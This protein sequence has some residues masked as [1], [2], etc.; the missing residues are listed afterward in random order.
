MIRRAWV[1]VALSLFALG[2]ASLAGFARL[3][4]IPEN[5]GGEVEVFNGAA[6]ALVVFY[7]YATIWQLFNEPLA[8]TSN[9]VTLLFV[10]V[11]PELAAHFRTLSRVLFVYVSPHGGG[12]GAAAL[13]P[14]GVWFVQ[15]DVLF[16]ITEADTHACPLGPFFGPLTTHA[17]GYV[18]IPD[19]V[20]TGRPFSFTIDGVNFLTLGPFCG[21]AYVAP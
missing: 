20:D 16:S 3:G 4:D 7:D 8:T 11:A 2:A 15:D 9:A 18:R 6:T 10:E 14:A 5:L 1:L 21:T 12:D 13:A 19:G 17:A